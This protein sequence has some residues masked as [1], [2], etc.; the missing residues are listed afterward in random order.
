MDTYIKNAI[1]KIL[2]QKQKLLM[3][4][5]RQRAKFEG[6]LKFELAHYLAKDGNKDVGVEVK[7]PSNRASNIR[8]DISFCKDDVR[9]YVE[10][11]TPNTNWRIEGIN[12]SIRP[13]TK[14]ID[15]ISA[16]VDKLKSLD[17]CS[18]GIVAFVLF[19]IPVNSNHYL[20]Y[21]KKVSGE[22]HLISS[23]NFKLL[24]FDIDDCNNC[25]MLICS[26]FASKTD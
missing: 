21:I 4:P 15:S 10:L 20:D 16:D 14:N 3:I 22:N 5:L 25:N 26:F 17:S 2:E 11:K 6:W 23:Y 7:I 19:P 24:Q 12:N 9:Y 18:K 8:A 13:I 1:C